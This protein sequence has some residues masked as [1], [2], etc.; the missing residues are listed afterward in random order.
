MENFVL[1]EELG[2]GDHSIIYKGRRKGTINFV[3][4]HCI[5]KCKRPEVTNTVRMTHDIQHL[6]VVKFYEWY[7]TSNHL[8]LVVELCTG[9]SLEYLITQDKNVPESSVRTFGIDLVTGLHYIHS[10]GILF[11]DLRPSKILLD[12]PGILKYADFG[13]AK[14]EGEN[15]EELFQK[16]ADAGETWNTESDFADK[17]SRTAGHTN[18]SAP[19]V[20]QGG[21]I[22]I[23]SDLWSLGCTMY[24]MFTGHPPFLAES[25]PQLVDKIVNKEFPPPKVKGTRFSS[26]PSPDFL[27][28]I[29][30]LL[31]KDPDKRLGW[32]G[33]VT[34]T[35]WQGKLAHLAK[36]LVMS[37]D[38]QGSMATTARSSVFVDGT[39]SVLGKVKNVEL[40][41]RPTT[42]QQPHDESLS[43]PGTAG[44]DFLRPKTAPSDDGGASLFTLSARPHTAVPP[45]DSLRVNSPYKQHASP[46]STREPVGIGKDTS[47]LLQT[48]NEILNLVYHP[49]DFSM[50]PIVD[51]PKVQRPPTAKYDAKT[52][53]VN[54]IS[55]E[56][57]SSLPE[58]DQTRHLKALLD[59]I[60]TSEKGPPSQKRIQVY[61]YMAALCNC[62][63]AATYLANN[64]AF[65][66][67]TKQL[68]EVTHAEVRVKIARVIGLMA[69]NTTTLDESTKVSEALTIIT[70]VFRENL[71]NTRVK[72]GLLPA[73]GELVYL[74]ASQEEKQLSAIENWN[75]P[76]MTFAVISRS[77]RDGEDAL[78]HHIAAKIVENVAT[79]TGQ[80][81]QK[82][83]TTEMA[84]SLWYIF[85]HSS[86]D[87]LRI[88][89]LSA[90]HRITKH[91]PAVFQSVIDT[92]GLSTLLS[93]LSF[94]I[95]RIQ[96]SIVT[97]FAT[98]IV[99]G[100]AV[101]RLT[102]DRDFL[103]KILRLLESPS[104]V[105][106]G[107]AFIVIHEM[108]RNNHD[109]LL[110]SCQ[111]RLVMYLERDCRRQTPR[112]TKTDPGEIEY[113]NQ[114]LDLL[115]SYICD[116]VPRVMD[117][118]LGALDAVAGRKH[119]N[120][121]Q[122]KQLKLALPL[123]HIFLHLV[124][125]QVF[126]PRIVN[127][128]FIK[129]LGK[130]LTHV[131]KIENGETNID[132][133]NGVITS[134]EFV[135][136]V[137]S[138]VEGITQH[139]TLLMEQGIVVMENIL[140]TLAELVVSQNGDTRVLSL[141]LFSEMA[142]V[143]LTQDAVATTA[144]IDTKKLHAIIGE[145][146]FPHYEQIL[147]DQDPLPFY[148]LKLLLALLESNGG[149]IKQFQQL[150]LVSVIFQVLLDHQNNPLSSA[151]QSIAGILNCLVGHKETNMKELYEQGLIDYFTT[152]FF[153]VSAACFEGEENT[154]VDSKVVLSMLQTLLETLHGLLKY[155]SD[156]VRKAL[157]AKKAGGEGS[158]KETEDAEHL[159]LQNKALTDLTSLLTQLLT[160]EDADIQDPACK[161]LSLLVQLFGGEH[162]EALNPENMDFY[163]KALK[164]ADAKKQKVLLRIIKR[165]VSTDK[166][167]RESMR[168]HGELLANTIKNLVKTASSHADVS[169][170]SLAAEILKMTGHLK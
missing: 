170:S 132:S 56:K 31:Q 101:N 75:I 72:Q 103:Q 167:H 12:G 143:F 168:A 95:S 97:M 85:K 140:P 134:S 124:T 100:S 39:G 29:E 11:C 111:L 123:V 34:H 53:P 162:K 131:K 61:H 154:G 114:C 116:A 7:E 145:K 141:S 67:L 151:M 150:G 144:K 63:E 1:Y 45:D 155:V 109:V 16:F 28:L 36:D 107:K 163:S 24:E 169:L 164:K 115:I 118:I 136:T 68:K 46:L 159:L 59:N 60:S 17:R 113:L 153:E 50:S 23:L 20:L 6:N 122:A 157:Q 49:S 66:V 125:S 77:C 3:A 102:Q 158:S 65:S 33:L 80:V 146:L 38:V 98:L 128:G 161:C 19:E 58:K 4:I 152:I 54:P 149:F 135:N 81:T 156:F 89:S 165:L 25:Y 69:N 9:G 18:Y 137:M 57:F 74:V 110:Q 133:T 2:R 5:E 86:L 130:L 76:S 84:Q 83:V 105:I 55:P 47:E 87:A 139:P 166:T 119:P 93:A 10:L 148:G 108:A 52:L 48:K 14:V 30:G 8:W 117:D 79:T 37:Q 99:S 142:T 42:T 35:F 92:V 70:E 138:V 44:G 51:N 71:K 32:P 21:E 88:T 62:K 104:T 121:V 90:L 27:S 160:H 43:R 78:I 106:R 64:N 73:M 120:N 129:S 91:N 96:Q 94:G 13:L 22:S 40:T 15:L 147:L 41:D 26:K 112:D 126:R 82:L 127:E